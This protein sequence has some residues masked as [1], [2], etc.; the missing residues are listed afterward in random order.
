M[1]RLGKGTAESNKRLQNAVDELWMYTEEL[2]F[3]NET[4]ILMAK[5]NIGPLN[6]DLKEMWMD[7]TIKTLEESNIIIPE[8]IHYTLQYGKN[9]YHT[10]YLGYLLA[11]MQH[12]P[13][14]YPEAK[15]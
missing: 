4:D 1:L 15:W 13:L 10:E 14:L 8:N 3:D 9:G 11:E 5:E 7:T 12:L 6:K 2:F